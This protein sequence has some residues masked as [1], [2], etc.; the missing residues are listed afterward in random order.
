MK[1]LDRLLDWLPWTLATICVA[2]S[3]HIISI[4]LMPEVAPRNAFARLAAAARAAPTTEAGVALLPRET[5]GAE[6][7]PFEDPAFAEGV[8]LF[9][10]SKGLMRVVADADPEDYLALSFYARTGRVFHAATDRSAIKGK[11]E[12]MIGDAAQIENLES[13]DEEAP[14][15][16]VRVTSPTKRGFVLIR[17][18]A[19][20]MSDRDR[21]EQ[22]LR[23]VKCETV[24][25]PES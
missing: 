11:I 19:K 7:M 12:V 21:A 13:Q 22:R 18:L 9:D 15:S 6:V 16:Q 8:C 1:L 23:M 4:L 25:E 14:P 10:L 5:P 2:G 24:A 17:S 20:R 3:V